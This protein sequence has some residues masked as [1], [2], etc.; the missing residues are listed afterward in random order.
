MYSTLL[1]IAG[2]H[3][4]QLSFPSC[5]VL[6]I[7]AGTSFFLRLQLSSQKSSMATASDMNVCLPKRTLAMP[8]GAS[9]QAMESCQSGEVICELP[10]Q[11]LVPNCRFGTHRMQ[12]QRLPMP[13]KSLF[14]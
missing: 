10:L 9:N 1:S 14:R 3:A 11:P 6:W 8:S 7:A 2:W 5:D 4:L 13:C 12:V